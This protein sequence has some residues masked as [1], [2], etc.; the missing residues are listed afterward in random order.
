M[1]WALF[2]FAIFCL[3]KTIKRS[4]SWKEQQEK[5]KPSRTEKR[6]TLL[7]ILLLKLKMLHLL[8]VWSIKI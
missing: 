4:T 5:R 7:L 3:L 1:K 2:S 8:L 6:T